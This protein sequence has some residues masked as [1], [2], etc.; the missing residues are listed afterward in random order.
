M[1]ILELH[2]PPPPLTSFHSP[3]LPTLDPESLALTAYFSLAIPRG[4]WVLIPS[5]PGANPTGLLPALRWGGVWV[6]GWG[7]VVDFVGKMG[8]VGWRLGWRLGGREGEEGNGNERGKG[9]GGEG[10][11]DVIA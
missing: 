3:S 2:V 1:P 10:R 9:E 8:G 11:G 4:E 6:G 5:L 7:N